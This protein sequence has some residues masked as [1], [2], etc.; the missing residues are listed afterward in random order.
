MKQLKAKI[1]SNRKVG[2]GFYKM[3]LASSYLAKASRPGQFVEIRCSRLVDPLLRRPLGVH[4]I[5]TRGIDL[6]YEVTG[7]GTAILS[8]RRAGEELDVIGPLGNGFDLSLASD[9]NILVAGGIGVAPLAALAES[10]RAK[11]HEALWVETCNF[12]SSER[13][14]APLISAFKGGVSGRRD[15]KI[16]ALIGAGTKSHIMCDAEFKSMGCDVRLS[17][18]DGSRGYKGRVTE[19]LVKLLDK[20]KLETYLPAFRRVTVYA[21]GP[22]AMLKVVSRIALERGIPCQVSLEERMACGIGICLGC[23]VKTKAGPYKMVCK[24]GPVFNAEE[25]AW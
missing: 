8:E 2:A 16:Y 1:L 9:T 7:K 20:C 24:D 21:C 18:D 14:P 3:E 17:T 23:P 11:E 12:H 6:L 10:L 19:P 13:N 4:R 5:W 25:L 15:K 22:T